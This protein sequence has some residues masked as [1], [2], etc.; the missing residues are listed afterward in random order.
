MFNLFYVDV[1]DF[2]D[3]LVEFYYE[4]EFGLVCGDDGLDL[5]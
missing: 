2:V 4:F 5:V 3:M 1:E